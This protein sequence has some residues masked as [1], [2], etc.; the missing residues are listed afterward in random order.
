MVDFNGFGAGVDLVPGQ[1]AKIEGIDRDTWEGKRLRGKLLVYLND[2]TEL[3]YTEIV[4]LDIFSDLQC[5]SLAP[6]Y[7]NTKK[8]ISMVKQKRNEEEEI[9]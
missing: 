5:S 8:R 9:D 6:I 7:R 2:L 3:P 4:K 1:I